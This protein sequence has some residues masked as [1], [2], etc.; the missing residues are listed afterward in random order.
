MFG[1]F[2]LIIAIACT[3]FK[4][5]LKRQ[6]QQDFS[7]THSVIPPVCVLAKKK[8]VDILFYVS[9]GHCLLHLLIFTPLKHGYFNKDEAFI[10]ENG[11]IIS[12]LM[13]AIAACFFFLKAKK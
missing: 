9:W 3:F 12:W 10:F 1:L 5:K 11:I 6:N 8:G 2:L 7:N 13:G 4:F